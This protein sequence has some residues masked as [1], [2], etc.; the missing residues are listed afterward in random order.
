MYLVMPNPI[1]ENVIAMVDGLPDGLG[2]DQ[3]VDRNRMYEKTFYTPLAELVEK[4][5]WNLEETTTLDAF[6]A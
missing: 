5:G 4:I 6:W 1:H 3:Y 2:L